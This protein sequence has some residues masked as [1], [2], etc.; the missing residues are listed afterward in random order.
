MTWK[1]L[2]ATETEKSR[3]DGNF[4][5]WSIQEFMVQGICD[6]FIMRSKDRA[7]RASMTKSRFVLNA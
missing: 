6:D 7:L 5:H 1:I 4:G 3:R 2:S